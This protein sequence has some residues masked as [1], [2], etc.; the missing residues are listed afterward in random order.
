MKPPA[1]AL[2]VLL[3]A[4]C[5]SPEPAPAPAATA[6]PAK[7]S[8]EWVPRLLARTKDVPDC[9]R[10]TMYSPEC[11][12][13]LRQVFGVVT[14]VGRAVTNHLMPERYAG[15][16]DAVRQAEQGYYA[17]RDCTDS[18]QD[19]VGCWELFELMFDVPVAIGN[20]LYADEK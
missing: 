20:A 12:E 5:S 16:A 11:A 18:E 2:A 3:L 15:T 9:S 10:S 1:L 17:Y 4:G 19:D 8:E 6:A 14:E 7:L 13:H